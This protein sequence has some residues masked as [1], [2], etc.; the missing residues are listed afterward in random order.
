MADDHLYPPYADFRLDP[1]LYVIEFV[2]DGV[3]VSSSVMFPLLLSKQQT[4]GKT[5]MQVLQEMA[6]KANA[7]AAL[8]KTIIPAL[9]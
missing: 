8:V 6:T 2:V 7:Y 9:P 5:G 3:P 4:A 1:K